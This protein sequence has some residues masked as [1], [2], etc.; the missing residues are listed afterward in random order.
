MPRAPRSSCATP[1]CPCLANHPSPLAR[2]GPPWPPPPPHVVRRR[3]AFPHLPK[4]SQGR[5]APC[6]TLLHLK[7]EP[8]P[9]AALDRSHTA[10]TLPSG[11]LAPELGHHQ[12][13]HSRVRVVARYSGEVP[14]LVPL[15]CI[16]QQQALRR[17]PLPRPAGPR[18]VLGPRWTALTPSPWFPAREP[19][20]QH[21]TVYYFQKLI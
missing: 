1:L 11:K 8:K 15:P 16:G 20:S 13:T 6:R 4:C 9:M 2:T 19:G 3:G 5:A 18:G 7:T 17:A 14:E 21:N 12:V 10:T